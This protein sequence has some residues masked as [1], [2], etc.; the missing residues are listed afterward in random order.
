MINL[1]KIILFALFAIALLALGCGKKDSAS[2]IEDVRAGTEG[3]S[4]SFVP[5]NPPDKVH[6]EKGA[7]TK[8]D[9]VLEIRNKGAFPQPEEGNNAPEGQ[10]YISG[11][12]NKIINSLAVKEPQKG[13]TSV[14]LID[15]NLQGRSTIN[16]N[17]GQD[18]AAFEAA[19]NY[20]SMNVKT[21]E[22]IFLATLC[23]YYR[24]VASP[25]VCID[26][27]P[28]STI[29][30]KK[31]CTA[32]DTTLASQGAPLA[33]VQVNEEAFSTK[34]QF[35]ITIKNVGGG[36]LI[37]PIAGDKC[38]PF[39]QNKLGRNDIDK[40]QLDYVKIAGGRMLDC[41]PFADGTAKGKTGIIRMINGEGS[42]VC[43][44]ATSNYNNKQS[45]YTTPLLIQLGY[46][47]RIT[48]QR[49][50]QLVKEVDSSQPGSQAST[51][52][53]TSGVYS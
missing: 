7:P 16:P 3:L 9:I 33:V 8:F 43:E 18:I 22:P 13:G 37:S 5:N 24:T 52:D 15:I 35:K 19:V 27:S 26:P 41:G 4:V 53:S 14:S 28:Y 21:Y 12:D 25:S 17:G 42:V 1:K 45:A 30:E 39:G 31:V 46:V 32:H 36:D 51:P 49:Q 47:Y 40:V 2:S 20:D 38:D 34:T 44:L 48:T 50:V 6:V 29:S 23:S 10:L 11:Y